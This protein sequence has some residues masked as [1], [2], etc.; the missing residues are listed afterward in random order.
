MLV[1]RNFDDYY[2]F[3]KLKMKIENNI[4][5]NHGMIKNW[6]LTTMLVLYRHTEENKRRRIALDACI[7]IGHNVNGNGVLAFSCVREWASECVW[8]CGKHYK[9]ACTIQHPVKSESRLPNA[10]MCNMIF[11]SLTKKKQQKKKKKKTATKQQ[12]QQRVKKKT[13]S[14]EIWLHSNN[15][16]W[17]HT[18]ANRMPS[19]HFMQAHLE[20]FDRRRKR[21]IAKREYKKQNKTNQQKQ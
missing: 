16:K 8:V 15:H 11:F 6:Q 18:G 14:T 17:P 1:W 10:V 4:K 3:H 19:M 5:I 21:T 9:L 20:P 7:A 13:H 12:L 2:N